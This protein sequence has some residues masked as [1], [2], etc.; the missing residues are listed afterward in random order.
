MNRSEVKFDRMV[1]TPAFKEKRVLVLS[2]E[3]LGFLPIQPVLDSLGHQ[4]IYQALLCMPASF[5]FIFEG[6]VLFS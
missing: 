3:I 2:F 6:T 5:Q 1:Q 4:S